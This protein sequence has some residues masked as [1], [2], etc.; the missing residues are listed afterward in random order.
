MSIMHFHGKGKQTHSPG[1]TGNGLDITAVNTDF[2]TIA[3]TVTL[4]SPSHAKVLR[5]LVFP[6][7]LSLALPGFIWK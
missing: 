4:P 6:S 7:E 5:R 2:W 1:T 3:C